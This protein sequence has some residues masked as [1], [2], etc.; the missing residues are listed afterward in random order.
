MLTTER[1]LILAARDAYNNDIAV[2]FLNFSGVRSVVIINVLQLP[3]R[4]SLS[5]IVS[6]EF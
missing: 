3:P 1:F 4:E 6:L 2:C 5:S